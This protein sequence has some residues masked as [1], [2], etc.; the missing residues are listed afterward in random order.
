MVGERMKFPLRWWVL[1]ERNERIGGEDEKYH[2]SSPTP[3][4]TWQ[5]CDQ[6]WASNSNMH[7]LIRSLHCRLGC[8]TIYELLI[9][10]S[11]T[12]GA[13][14]PGRAAMPTPGNTAAWRATLW[15]RMEQLMDLIYSACGQVQL[16]FTL[17]KHFF[18]YLNSQVS[19]SS[20]LSLLLT[21]AIYM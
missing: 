12:P 7:C 3:N 5:F 11:N 10:I 14:G 20:F 8:H 9:D 18:A 1:G 19:S 6:S 13:G 16:Y 15:T 17:H 4:H 21:L 2:P